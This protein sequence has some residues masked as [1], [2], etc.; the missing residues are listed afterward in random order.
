M[1][2]RRMQQEGQD[3]L[4]EDIKKGLPSAVCVS[5]SSDPRTVSDIIRIHRVETRSNCDSV[6]V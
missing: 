1:Q 3:T 4:E 6:C 5:F 2:K